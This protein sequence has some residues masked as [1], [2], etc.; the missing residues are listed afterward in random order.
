LFVKICSFFFFY[1]DIFVRELFM[2]A[3]I[4]QNRHAQ[5]QQINQNIHHK[6]LLYNYFFMWTNRGFST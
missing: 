1:I 5:F 6:A 4:C 2:S 3:N